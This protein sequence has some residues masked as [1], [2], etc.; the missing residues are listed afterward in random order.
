M[1]EFLFGPRNPTRFWP[2][3]FR[4][5]ITFDL[6][7]ASLSGVRLGQPLDSLSFLGLDEVSKSFRD[8]QL[9]YPSQG[10]AVRFSLESQCVV[11]YRIVQSDPLDQRFQPFRGV[12]LFRGRQ[13]NLS[14]LSPERFADE[15]GDFYWQDRDEEESIL[16]FESAGLEWQIEFSPDDRLRCIA[17]TNEPIMGSEEQRLAYNVTEPWPPRTLKDT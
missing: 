1:F 6:D 5:E 2:P 14:T 11:E 16:F 12:V 8:G 13:V 10:L 17:I 3:G 4:R 9:L 15:Y 7:E